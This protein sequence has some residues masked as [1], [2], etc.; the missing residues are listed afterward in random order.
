MWLLLLAAVLPSSDK[1]ESASGWQ[2]PTVAVKP[3]AWMVKGLILASVA[4]HVWG[5]FWLYERFVGMS[6]LLALTN[7]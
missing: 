4:I 2:W 1:S 3:P 7:R 6:W 5:F